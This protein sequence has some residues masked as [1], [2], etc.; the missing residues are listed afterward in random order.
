LNI[1]AVEEPVPTLEE[2]ES[3]YSNKDIEEIAKTHLAQ[4][5]VKLALPEVSLQIVDILVGVSN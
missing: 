4:P 3:L 5:P 2:V 1:S